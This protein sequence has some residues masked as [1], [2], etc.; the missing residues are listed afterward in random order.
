MYLRIQLIVHYLPHQDFLG[1]LNERSEQRQLVIQQLV[2]LLC[3]LLQLLVLV[4]AIL[5]D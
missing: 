4:L 5:V 3:H 2:H 1:R